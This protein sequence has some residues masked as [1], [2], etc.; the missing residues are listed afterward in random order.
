MPHRENHQPVRLLC[1]AWFC[2]LAAV[3]CAGGQGETEFWVLS[4]QTLEGRHGLSLAIADRH[5]AGLFSR[6][7]MAQGVSAFTAGLNRRLGARL[8]LDAG[9]ALSPS[10]QASRLD[11]RDYFLGIS[12]RNLAG[13][14]W[15]QPDPGTGR[16]GY[17]YEAGWQGSL[18]DRFSLSLGLGQ[19]STADGGFGSLLPDFSFGARARLGS[20]GIGL[21]LIERG[22]SEFLEPSSLR[23]M[24]NISGSF[25]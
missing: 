21:R 14:F 5:E 23:L 6:Y 22:G 20:V 25:H 3:A 10:G 16:A 11:Y 24:G 2:C 19:G 7:D 18:S 1:G 17:Y 13:R 15:Y 4:S 8:S 12:Y 9:L